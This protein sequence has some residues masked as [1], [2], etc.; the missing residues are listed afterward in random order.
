MPSDVDADLTAVFERLGG[1][2]F[3]RQVAHLIPLDLDR[4]EDQCVYLGYLLERGVLVQSANGR[5]DHDD[6]P[7]YGGTTP[8]DPERP[9]YNLRKW[10]LYHLHPAVERALRASVPA[11]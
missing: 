7:Q 9:G 1:A 6:W 2:E 5:T 8:G 11:R 10:N 3:M 4:V